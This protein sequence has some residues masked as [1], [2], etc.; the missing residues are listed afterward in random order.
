MSVLF[1]WTL[2]IQ[3][4]DLKDKKEELGRKEGNLDRKKKRREDGREI[5]VYLHDLL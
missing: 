4:F 2:K 1:Y 3:S 5:Q